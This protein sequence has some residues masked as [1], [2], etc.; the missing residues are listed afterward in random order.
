MTTTFLH[1]DKIIP[2]GEEV[3]RHPPACPECGATMG[4][5][6]FTRSSSDDGDR[7]VRSYECKR[8][9]ALKDVIEQAQLE[10]GP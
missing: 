7:D 3:D 2:A 8:C 4:L 6:H 1:E 5:V 10:A 9:G